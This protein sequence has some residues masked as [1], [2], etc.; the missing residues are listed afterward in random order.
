MKTSSIAVVAINI[1]RDSIVR[2][3][4]KVNCLTEKILYRTTS[5]LHETMLLRTASCT[6]IHKTALNYIKPYLTSSNYTKLHQLTPNYTK[7]QQTIL[8]NTKFKLRTA[9]TI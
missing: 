8:N 6:K 9:T 7:L 4:N 2:Q 5:E 1:Q 3:T